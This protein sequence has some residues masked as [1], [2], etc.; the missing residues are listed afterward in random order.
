MGLWRRT[1]RSPIPFKGELSTPLLRFGKNDVFTTRDAVESIAI[2]GGMGSGKTSGS[3]RALATA[4][5]RCGYGGLVMCATVNEAE[6]WRKLAAET[7]RTK[8]LIFLD[9][10]GERRFNFMDYAQSVL[11]RNGFAENVNTIFEEITQAFA[12][13]QQGGGGDNAFFREAAMEQI[14]HTLPVLN[15]AYGTIRI[16][17]VMRFIDSAPKSEKDLQSREWRQR[18][19][20]AQTLF[21]AHQNAVQGTQI[22]YDL[23]QHGIHWSERY[24]Y[25][26]DKTRSSITATITT[27]LSPFLTGQLNQIFCTDTNLL[28]EYS[29]EGAIIVLNLPVHEYGKLG[30]VCQKIFKYLWQK[31]VQR[32]EA[33]EKTR[34]VFLWA[35]EC[36]YFISP[37]D[38]QFV[39][40]SRERKAANVYI[41]QDK[42]SYMAAIKAQGADESAALALLGKFQTKIFHA[43]TD[44]ETCEYASGII[45][46]VKKY[47]RSRS[48]TKG[49]GTNT[50]G[51]Q[52]EDGGGNFGGGGNQSSGDTKG[53]TEY[54]D[55]E[56]PP[57][58]FGTGLRKGGPKN[59][60]MVDAI[61]ITTQEF[62]QASGR[63]RLKVEFS[64]K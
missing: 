17:D 27:T 55:Y 6:R 28:P 20:C 57:E 61:L 51:N 56:I 38:S 10:S 59:R 18:S 41:T 2:F 1:P 47:H 19:F 43:N 54:M 4:F 26:A 46:K 39:G 36:Q 31:S 42:P 49:T 45:G 24:P 7:D 8:S 9:A 25:I 44:T 64:Q 52:G 40:T 60:L 35:D 53:W 48:M 13:Q 32:R 12:S 37:E 58:Y 33:D 34:P 30:A 14:R 15:A 22:A 23:E 29:H 16:K 21:K 5:L 63:N 3:G 50:G 62:K 11:G